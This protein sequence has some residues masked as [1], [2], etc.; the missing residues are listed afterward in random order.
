MKKI[1][2]L[3][4]LISGCVFAQETYKNADSQTF[5]SM[6]EKKDGVVIDLRTNDECAK[7]MLRGAVQVDFLG[8]DFE[9]V[10]QKMDKTKKYYVYCQ[11]GGRSAEAAEWMA[12]NGFKNVVNLEKGYFDWSKKGFPTEVRK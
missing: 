4:V 7:G 11:G 3:F 10:M 9:A 1:L 8:K 6:I 12:K 2:L 5:K